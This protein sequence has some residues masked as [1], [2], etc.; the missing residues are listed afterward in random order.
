MNHCTKPFVFFAVLFALLAGCRQP[1]ANPGQ[2]RQAM[3]DFPRPNLLGSS[4]AFASSRQQPLQIQTGTPQEYQAYSNLSSQLT[5]LQ[6]RV[7]AYDSDNQQLHTE[8]AGLKQ[9]LQLADEYNQQLKQQ[10]ADTASQYQ[11]IQREKI[12][13]EGQL[14]ANRAQMQQLSSQSQFQNGQY[15]QQQQQFQDQQ[16]QQFAQY[17]GNGVPA[18]LAGTATVRANNSLLNRLSEINIPGGQARMD[19]DVIRI[20]FPSDMMFVPGTYDIQPAQAPLLENLAT[21]IRQSFPR[22]IIGIEAHWDKT[23]LNPPG[24]TDH[25]LTATQALAVFN[26]MTRLGLSPNQLFTMAMGS[27]RPRYPAG[28]RGSISPNRRIEI[29]IYPESFD[30]T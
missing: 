22:Q 26:N 23:P 24:T 27:N 17:S 30:G 19:G 3:F 13:V 18:T 4:S 9:K 20:E 12:S 29:V 1:V 16:R 6:Q 10:L 7:G 28:N 15:L 21:T 5:D 11:Q 25:Q 14:A 2:P 8:V